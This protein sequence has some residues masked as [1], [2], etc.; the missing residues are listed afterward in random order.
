MGMGEG[1]RVLRRAAPVIAGLAVVLAPLDGAAAGTDPG[2]AQIQRQEQAQLQRLPG[3]VVNGDTIDYPALGVELMYYP[4][5]STSSATSA[6]AVRPMDYGG[7]PEGDVCLYTQQY[8][9]GLALKTS[10]VWCPPEGTNGWL[11]L[12]NFG[13]A[14]Q[15]QSADSENFWYGQG[16][17]QNW[18]GTEGNQWHLQP[19]GDVFTAS[20]QNIRYLQVCKKESDW[21]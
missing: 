12:S 6:R 8:L 4:T 11:D 17:W 15:V 18:T 13:L 1:M 21:Y 16:I 9:G 5:A 14:G 7:C 3:G 19:F 2:Q 10:S 20:P